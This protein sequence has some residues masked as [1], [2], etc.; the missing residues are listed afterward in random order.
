VEEEGKGGSRLN[1]YF[2]H[3]LRSECALR[4]LCCS[5]GQQFE[6]AVADATSDRRC[7]PRSLLSH[8]T[9]EFEGSFED[10]V[11]G[12]TSVQDTGKVPLSGTA[13]DFAS[14]VVA[15][16]RAAPISAPGFV[17]VILSRGSILADV[18]LLSGNAKEMALDRASRGT[19][20]ID[21]GKV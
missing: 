17:E 18:L 8:F 14:A 12:R 1:P 4:A 15:M 5:S 2:A 7:E 13:P 16:L 21:K 6:S 11:Q 3:D 10:V 19:C 9:L 20:L